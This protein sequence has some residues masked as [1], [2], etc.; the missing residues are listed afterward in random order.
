M[1]VSETDYLDVLDLIHEAALEPAAWERVLR[2][3]A[4]LTNCVAGGLTI[5]NA[6]T[7]EGMPLVYFGFDE[8][9][10]EKTFAHYL[11]MNPLFRIAPRM[12]PG[13]IVGN[14]DVVPLEDFR[15]T[16]F[17][18]GWA[19][20]QGLCCPITVVLHREG[21]VY[22][23][24]TLVRPDGAGDATDDERALLRRLTPHLVR[25][26]GI[27]MQLDSLRHQRSA[28]EAALAPLALV[29]LLLGKD[30]RVVFANR[31]AERLFASGSPLR[32]AKG[33]LACSDSRSDRELQRAILGVAAGKAD[34][35]TEIQIHRAKGR[36]LIA[37]VLP[38]PGESRF[39]PDFDSCACCAVLIIDPDCVQRSRTESIARRCGLTRAETNLLDSI[40]SGT[41][42][43]HAADQL[44][45]TQ[46]TARTHLQRV[47]AKTGTGRQAELV[48]LVM[49]STPPLTLRN[50]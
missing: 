31:A 50:R 17:Y 40:L 25:A 3:I 48:N 5:E 34:S 15:R 13:F 32:T 24:L 11:P 35:G 39:V 47:F 22:C 14:G 21:D 23:P 19:R 36:P 28:I 37:T 29:F 43:Q 10:V 30:R 12:T 33:V 38:V 45:V 44:G 26:M 27:G 4:S 7:R 20:P 2:R 18:D 6:R 42:L 1:V 49:T 9:H 8:D 46:A 16:E 41:G